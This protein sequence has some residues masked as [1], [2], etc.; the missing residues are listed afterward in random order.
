MIIIRVAY[1]LVL[2]FFYLGWIPIILAM[3]ISSMGGFILDHATNQFTRLAMFQPVVNGVGGNLVAV[4]ASRLSTYLHKRSKLG[5]FPEGIE[6]LIS[7]YRAFIGS[8]INVR[9]ARVLLMMSIP[10]HFLYLGVFR[11]IKG[12][13]GFDMT[14]LFL[15]TYIIFAV[16][17]VSF[18][19]LIPTE[20]PTFRS[21]HRN[22]KYK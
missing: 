5:H 11:I 12:S 22:Q 18:I 4:Q 19:S 13:E 16:F 3:L 21:S 14:F 6:C 15:F 8:T 9:T 10:A 7:P 1:Y 17:Q 20:G 2:E